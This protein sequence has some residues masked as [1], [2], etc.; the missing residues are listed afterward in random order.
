MKSRIQGIAWADF[1]YTY[2]E[3]RDD[4]DGLYMAIELG[5]VAVGICV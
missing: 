1:E 3:T 2:E 5:V 4:I